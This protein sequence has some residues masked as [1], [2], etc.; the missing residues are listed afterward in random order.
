VAVAAVFCVGEG[1]R[2]EKITAFDGCVPRQS[3]LIF[4]EGKEIELS[5]FFCVRF[6]YVRLAGLLIFCAVDRFGKKDGGEARHQHRDCGT[7]PE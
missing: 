4:G 2:L 5:N 6:A 1:C 3:K 7:L